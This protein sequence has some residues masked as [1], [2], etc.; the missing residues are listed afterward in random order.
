MSCVSSIQSLSRDRRF[1]CQILSFFWA[2]GR[3]SNNDEPTIDWAL[4]FFKCSSIF[5][6]SR[7]RVRLGNPPPL[8][9]LKF[10]GIA[11]SSNTDL[12]TSRS[13]HSRTK[14]AQLLISN[15]PSR[16]CILFISSQ[17]V[18]LWWTSSFTFR[19]WTLPRTSVSLICQFPPRGSIF[20][21]ALTCIG[22]SVF[23]LSLLCSIRL[24][25]TE[26]ILPVER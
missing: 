23:I 8:P 26:I 22:W 25:Q 7:I 17:R 12:I 21:A 19:T 9:Q 14:T 24:L 10:M 18:T 15:P 6:F 5:A 3:N 16:D 4:F 13:F 2:S 1:S 20:L 11:D